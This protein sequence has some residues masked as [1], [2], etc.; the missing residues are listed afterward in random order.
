MRLNLLL[1]IEM[2]GRGRGL[3]R[4]SRRDEFEEDENQRRD[5]RRSNRNH[6]YDDED[7]NERYYG[8]VRT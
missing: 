2:T 6:S 3:G 8:N 4:I 7:V 5:G 1:F